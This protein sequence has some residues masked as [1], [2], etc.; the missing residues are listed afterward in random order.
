MGAH[1][2]RSHKSLSLLK[3]AC[4]LGWQAWDP[5]KLAGYH[6]TAGRAVINA[7]SLRQPHLVMEALKKRPQVKHEL[8]MVNLNQKK[9][10][11]AL[12]Q[13]ARALKHEK[14]CALDI[15]FHDTG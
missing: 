15:N 9:R 14:F 3:K 13:F 4:G 10:L 12:E 11:F 6:K 1:F 8:Y 2:A 5:T 7:R